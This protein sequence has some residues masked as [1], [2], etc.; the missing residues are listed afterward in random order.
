LP[1]R[2]EWNN[3]ESAVGSS[4]GKKLKSSSG[5]IDYNGNDGNGTDD[6]GFSALPGGRCISGG[7]F[8][9]ADGNYGYWWTDTEIDGG[10]AYYRNMGYGKD[11]VDE[12]YD[13][14][15]LGFSVRCV[16]D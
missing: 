15:S 6:F 11:R 2:Q 4:A 13:G 5:W 12:S 1:S 16:A 14:K 9:Y 8:D 10:Y 7:Y 3:L